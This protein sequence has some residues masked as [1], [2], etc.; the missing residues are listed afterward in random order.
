MTPSRRTVIVSLLVLLLAGGYLLR[1]IRRP[2]RTP[3]TGPDPFDARVVSVFD[4]DTLRV[5]SRTGVTRLVRLQNVECPET[6]PNENCRRD[7]RRGGWSCARQ[8]SP[9]RKARRFVRNRLAD[10]PVRVIP[11]SSA[12][13]GDGHRLIARIRNPDGRDLG[14]ALVE[15]GLCRPWLPEPPEGPD[16]PF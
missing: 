7:G 12:S 6:R 4:G 13:S 3:D 14:E 16:P 9:G 2:T 10:T 1:E 5:R 11:R 15:A 8:L